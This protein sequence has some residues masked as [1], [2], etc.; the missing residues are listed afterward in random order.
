QGG[1]GVATFSA[2]GSNTC[3]STTTLNLVVN[4]SKRDTLTLTKCENE[5]PFSWNGFSITQAGTAVATF[6]GF[7]SANCDSIVVL[8]VM[9]RDTFRFVETQS[10]CVNSFPYVW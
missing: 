8:N 10:T 7:T 2:I 6:N 3:D 5:M 4:P 9:V 1:N